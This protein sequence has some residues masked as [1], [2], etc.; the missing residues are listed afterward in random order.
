MGFPQEISNTNYLLAYEDYQASPQHAILYGGKVFQ[1]SIYLTGGNYFITV[2][3]ST[4]LIVWTELDSGNRKAT[5]GPGSAFGVVA[6]GQYAYVAHNATM[7][8]EK[9]DFASGTWQS[10]VATGGPLVDRSPD[11]VMNTDNRIFLI[12]KSNAQFIIYYQTTPVNVIV[13]PSRAAY[14]TLT[15]STWGTPVSLSGYD[16]GATQSEGAAALFL[17]DADRVHFFWAV[18][19]SGATELWHRSLSSGGTLD[20][21]TKISN[22]YIQHFSS[23]FANM[24]TIGRGCVQGGKL[25]VP[26]M[27]DLSPGAI[28]MSLAVA[29]AGANPSWIIEQIPNT[30]FGSTFFPISS[31]STDVYGAFSFACPQSR[32]FGIT[33]PMDLNLAGQKNYF[34]AFPQFGIDE[35]NIIVFIRRKS[36]SGAG[37]GSGYAYAIRTA[38]GV[39]TGPLELYRPSNAAGGPGVISFFPAPLNICSGFLSPGARYSI[40]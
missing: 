16:G 8:M 23:P 15:G 13:G 12:Q 35:T 2:H 22:A 27:R 37:F 19:D 29:V 7:K 1:F 34:N 17:G 28:E 39:W 30:A 18:K 3:N 11:A 5:S 32:F 31:F 6:S 14:V 20:T 25:Y 24:Q 4:D 40:E 36:D 9:F 33:Q 26:F 21:A 10:T 38:A